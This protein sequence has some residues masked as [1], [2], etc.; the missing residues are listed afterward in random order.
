MIDLSAVYRTTRSFIASTIG[1]E[2]S[3]GSNGNPA[4]IKARSKGSRPEYPFATMDILTITDA[5]SY[6]TNRSTNDAGQTVYA[7]HKLITMQLSVRANSKQSYELTERLNKAL[8][9]L[10]VQDTF[11]TDGNAC[12]VSTEG[13]TATPDPLADRLQE[14]NSFNLVLGVDDVDTDANSFPL[15]AVT[16][17]ATVTDPDGT[18]YP[19]TIPVDTTP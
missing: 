14:F 3:T 16:I 9:F 13:I 10:P 15:E 17:T 5:N 19:A 2:L 6:L 12:V 1:S 7:T 4:I 8:T 18:E 11:I